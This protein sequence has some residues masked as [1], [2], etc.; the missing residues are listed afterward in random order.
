[1]S[2]RQLPLLGSEAIKS[3][4]G[5][6]GFRPGAPDGA[7]SQVACL[8]EAKWHGLV[9]DADDDGTLIRLSC[10]DAHKDAM[11]LTADFI[12]EYS[13][14]CGADEATIWWDAPSGTSGCR[15]EWDTTT[16]GAAESVPVTA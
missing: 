2:G 8:A 16:L 13:P 1:M 14:A 11:A 7:P 10:C 15:I 4:T 5:S 9:I 3:H 6:C 12:H